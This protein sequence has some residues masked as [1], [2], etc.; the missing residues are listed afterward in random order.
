MRLCLVCV[1]RGTTCCTNRDILLSDGD[2]LRITAAIG[3]QDFYEF[4]LASSDEYLDHPDD[5][6]WN[7]YTVQYDGRRRVLKH[8]SPG[9]CWFL[10]QQGCLLAEGARPLV[11]RLHPVEFNEERIT[12]LSSECPVQ[13]LAQ[14]ESLLENISMSLKDAELWRRQL[15]TELRQG[16]TRRPKAA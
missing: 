3:G 15:Y 8:S 11:C 10:S 7:V 1:G 13:Y 2:I 5:P 16:R 6:N 12:G 4:R 9:V 14:G